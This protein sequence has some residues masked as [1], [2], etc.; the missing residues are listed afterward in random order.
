MVTPTVLASQTAPVRVAVAANFAGPMAQLGQQFEQASGLKVAISVGSTGKFY[1]QIRQAAPF[2]VL[3]AADTLAIEKLVAEGLVEPSDRFTYA[4]GQLALWSPKQGLFDGQA[5]AIKRLKTGSFTRL[6][7][8]NPAVAPYG[9]AAQAVL[10]HLGLSDA[11]ANKRVLGQSI[12]QA[13]QFVASGNAELGFVAL[14]QIQTNDRPITGSV[15]LPP[16]D[17]HRPI[18]QD[19]ALLR[20]SPNPMAAKAFM[21][22]LQSHEARATIE[23]FGYRLSPQK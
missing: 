11:W 3:L 22:F 23:R 4:I 5:Q 20:N 2:D 13:Y 16:A 10:T 1:A 7:M 18:E 8:A 9:A 15:W 17:W 19:A 14:S 6:A 21:A 12:G